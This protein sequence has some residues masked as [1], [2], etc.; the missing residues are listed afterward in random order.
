MSEEIRREW[1]RAMWTIVTAAVIALAGSFVQTYVMQ[2]S[3]S[4]QLDV[5]KQEQQVIRSKIDL[6]QVQLERKVDR[7]TLDNCL[8]RID[9]KL[10]KI[11]DNIFDI[12]QKNF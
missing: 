4:G 8:N 1:R 12:Q 3:M 10:D 5:M 2:Q 7:G 9:Q 6:M 11:A